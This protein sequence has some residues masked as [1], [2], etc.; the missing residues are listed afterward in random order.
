MEGEPRCV[1]AKSFTRYIMALLTLRFLLLVGWVHEC[2]YCM[3]CTVLCGAVLLWCS[4]RAADIRQD[5][6]TS[7]LG[8]MGK[9][10][11][12]DAWTCRHVA[13]YRTII[14]TWYDALAM[15]TFWE[16]KDMIAGFV[17]Y[18]VFLF[19]L[20]IMVVLLHQDVTSS[21]AYT[22]YTT[23]MLFRTTVSQLD[24][25]ENTYYIAN[26]NLWYYMVLYK[27]CVLH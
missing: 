2:C 9:K 12:D 15:V 4:V 21:S 16:V 23:C 1:V 13:C 11:H 10:C 20:S 6:G 3:A 24:Y 5:S 27:R 8:A 17:N 22:R 19:L 18:L 7:W 14:M 25:C 26:S